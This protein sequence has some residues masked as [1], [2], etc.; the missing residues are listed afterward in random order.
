MLSVYLVGGGGGGGWG[1]GGWLVVGW[2]GLRF[3]A[4]RAAW[5]LEASEGITKVKKLAE[6]LDTEHPGAA[7]SL[8]E[9]AEELHDQS[10]RPTRKPASVLGD[11]QHNRLGAF[12]HA[13]EDQTR[14]ELARRRDG[15][16]MGSGSII[17][18]R[19]EISLHHGTQ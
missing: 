5:R 6:W 8:R 2:F 4:L 13:R 12:R 11:N 14:Y 16:A 9:G 10:A 3:A 19:S 18:N 1:G 15:T 7:G 17:G